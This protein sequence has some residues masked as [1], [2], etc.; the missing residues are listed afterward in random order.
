MKKCFWIAF[1]ATGILALSQQINAAEIPAK[2]EIWLRCSNCLKCCFSPSEEKLACGSQEL[3]EVHN[4]E[5]K[6]SFPLCRCCFL[7]HLETG[8]VPYKFFQHVRCLK[9]GEL[10]SLYD[11]GIIFWQEGK[12]K[13][14]FNCS[15]CRVDG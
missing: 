4:V 15:G 7:N 9:C 11:E 1:V 8:E 12:F 3:V 2:S 10:F 14:F 13:F 5:S 6:E